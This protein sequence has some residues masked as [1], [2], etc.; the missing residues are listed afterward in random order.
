[1]LRKLK[2]LLIEEKITVEKV[3]QMLNSWHGHAEQ[4]NSYTFIQSLLK[5]FD[6][7]ELIEVVRKGKKKNIFKVKR[8][9][10]ENARKSYLSTQRK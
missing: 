4:A 3:E 6:Y 9:V 5:R 8:E 1:M 7:I 10:I 2:G